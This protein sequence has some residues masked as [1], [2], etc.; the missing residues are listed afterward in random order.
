MT[1]L[2]SA[3][4]LT[5]RRGGTA[6]LRNVNLELHAGEL[7]VLVGPNGAG[8]TTLL[9]ALLGDLAPDS[10]RIRLFGAE[11][12]SYRPL[13]RARLLTL[14]P[15]EQPLDFPLRARELVELGRLPHAAAGSSAREDRAAVESALERTGVQHLAERDLDSLSGGERQRVGLARALAQATPLLM[16]DEPTAHLDVAHQIVMLEILRELARQGAAVLV[17]LHDLGLAARFADRVI[18]LD[19]GQVAAQ[20]APQE[21][22]TSELLATHFGIT[23]RIEQ[24]DDG[25]IRHLTVLGAHA[26]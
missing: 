9:R 1:M 14:V 11:L 2:L 22:L 8:K 17:A 13:A 18:V 4:D 23:T 16:L 15:Q 12:S 25:R 19:R 20:G 26:C 7:G 5:L 21:V 3:H 10:G 6:L 24:G